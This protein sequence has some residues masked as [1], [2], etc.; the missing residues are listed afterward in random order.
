MHWGKKR[1]DPSTTEITENGTFTITP[2]NT[3]AAFG[4]TPYHEFGH[5]IDNFFRWSNHEL[6]FLSHSSPYFGIDMDALYELDTKK[7]QLNP[8]E[9]GKIERIEF[10][11]QTIGIPKIKLASALVVNILDISSSCSLKTLI[12]LLIII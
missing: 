10:K 4:G 6:D 1:V 5:A 3:M 7:I 8:L 9:G 11:G 12:S 2:S